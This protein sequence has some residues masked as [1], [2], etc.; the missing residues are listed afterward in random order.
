MMSRVQSLNMMSQ[1][2]T[3]HPF[4][5]TWLRSA[6]ERRVASISS[7]VDL[8]SMATV[9]QLAQALTEVRQQLGEAQRVAQEAQR[10]GV[11]ASMA[12]TG[13]VGPRV[14]KKCPTFSGRG[15]GWS[16]WS[17]IFEWRPWRIWNLCWRAHSPG[18]LRNGL[19][20]SLL[21]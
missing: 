11:Q 19:Q 9:E 20:S 10:A 3:C 14:M 18:R 4:I 1:E 21:R 2:S 15:T 13:Q 6:V 17:F 7:C 5:A 12:S 16:G 8:S